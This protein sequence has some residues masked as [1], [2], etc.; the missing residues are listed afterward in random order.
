[1]FR[2]PTA[3]GVGAA[4]QV[5]GGLDQHRQRKSTPIWALERPWTRHRAA[6]RAMSSPARGS[7]PARRGR[8]TGGTRAIMEP[9][10]VR[11]R[12]AVSTKGRCGSRLA[13]LRQPSRPRSR[14]DMRGEVRAQHGALVE[15]YTSEGCSSCPPAD[16]W[17]SACRRRLRPG[18]R[19]AP[20]APCRLLGLHRLEGPYA[21]REFSL[22]QRKLT[23]LQRSRSSIPRR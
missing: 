15:L 12:A 18:A 22:R 8:R 21:K 7:T 11:P 20:R 5:Q 16:R 14:A 19:G 4:D 2:P 3:V 1:M 10:P 17:L 23:Q 6:P 9:D 13:F